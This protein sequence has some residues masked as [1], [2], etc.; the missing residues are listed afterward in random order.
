MLALRDTAGY[1]IYTVLADLV[2]NCIDAEANKINIT[3]RQKKNELSVIIA[4]NGY[5]MSA[6]VLGEAMRLG[7]NLTKNK[8]SDLGYYGM[9]LSVAPLSLGKCTSVLTSRSDGEWVKAVLDLD[10]IEETNKW[11]L[12]LPGIREEDQDIIDEFLPGA[13]SGTIIVLTK[14]DRMLKNT[15]NTTDG[16]KKH[17]SR[18]FWKKIS[19]GIEI[20][21][22]QKPIKPYDPLEWDF[23][24]NSDHPARFTDS[25]EIII[26]GDDVGT[27]KYKII[28]LPAPLP[29]IDNS[30]QVGTNIKTCGFY[31]Y[32][33]DR[34]IASGETLDIFS[35]HVLHNR[36]RGSISFNADELDE[37]M[38]TTFV[39][40]NY[41]ENRITQSIRDS[42]KRELKPLVT[43]CYKITERKALVKAGPDI[44]K[45]HDETSKE[46]KRNSNVLHLPRGPKEKRKSPINTGTKKTGDNAR[47]R[48][49]GEHVQEG[50]LKN[51]KW[52][53]MDLGITGSIYEVSLDKRTMIITWNAQHPL[54]KKAISDK[55]LLALMDY[56]VHSMASAE[57]KYQ[58]E[59]EHEKS[60]DSPIEVVYGF[61][62]ILSN[63]LR[64]LLSS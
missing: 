49:V 8:S 35:K 55:S 13:K 39:K 45:V 29:A 40:S 14:L 32:R 50:K 26:N 21:I 17:L 19:Q 48:G 11:E 31:V 51:V 12:L 37:G 56:I 28:L 9:G 57:L 23:H 24:N 62:N 30:R 10:H 63:N 22:N 18:I 16:L 52:Q 46:I 44:Q 4:D 6:E 61:K 38:G 43:Q 54:Y 15:T 3:V 60:A 36:F 33:N 20:S 27:I 7:S 42:L 59:P 47:F 5:G 41:D 2:D 1:N 58:F 53:H 34:E 25:G 64:V